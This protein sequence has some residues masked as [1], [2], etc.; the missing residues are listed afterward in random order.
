[1]H[2]EVFHALRLQTQ[3]MHLSQAVLWKFQHELCITPEGA[4]SNAKH[5]PDVC[6][7]MVLPGCLKWHREAILLNCTRQPTPL[8]TPC[9][10]AFARD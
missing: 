4:A 10:V 1:M 8:G 5:Y 3:S 2:Q 7:K 9:V 6:P